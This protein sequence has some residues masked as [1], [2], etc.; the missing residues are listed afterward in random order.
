[1]QPLIEL[2]DAY[3]EK[4]EKLADFIVSFNLV[5]LL[6]NLMSIF[7]FLPLKLLFENIQH[8]ELHP[9]TDIACF[10]SSFAI[11]F[12]VLFLIIQSKT[13]IFTK[14]NGKYFKIY[15]NM[16]QKSHFG[17]SPIVAIILGVGTGIFHLIFCYI[18]I[19]Y[20]PSID[21]L[22]SI[23]IYIVLWELLFISCQAIIDK[24]CDEEKIKNEATN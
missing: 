7:I 1:M 21:I 14:R 19:T 15:R 16:I 3:L 5:Q 20:L 9:A 6:A 2:F 11:V 22:K 23:P 24:C 10:G 18:C 4:H 17:N 13:T 12:F 8:W